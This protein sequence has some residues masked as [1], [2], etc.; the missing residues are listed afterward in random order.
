[1]WRN[2]I[3]QALYQVT[4]MLILQFEVVSIFGVDKKVNSTLI[5]NTFVLFQV[6]NKLNARKLE[7][8]N[9]FT[10]LLTNKMFLAMIGI[11]IIIQVIMVES[12][13]KVCQH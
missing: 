5:F 13:E 2:I 6:F 1:M 4:I 8:K 7:K 9:V 10:G 3:A 12:L 11:T